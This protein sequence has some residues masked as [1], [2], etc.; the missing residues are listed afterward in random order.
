[1][2]SVEKESIEKIF[3]HVD[4]Q[5]DDVILYLGGRIDDDNLY[6]RKYRK[7]LRGQIER[8]NPSK[9]ICHNHWYAKKY[10]ENEILS[11]NTKID[12][13]L[14][15]HCYFSSGEIQTI[16]PEHYDDHL[17]WI[18][19]LIDK[20]PNIIY[21]LCID[22]GIPYGRSRYGTQDIGPSSV[23]VDD[24]WFG[25]DY[26]LNNIKYFDYDRRTSAK[27]LTGKDLGYGGEQI[28]ATGGFAM[29]RNILNAGFKN[30]NI[31]GFSAFGS[32]EDQ[33]HFTPY[34]GQYRQYA[35]VKYFN[36]ATSENQEAE[37]DILKYLVENERIYNLEDYETLKECLALSDLYSR[38]I[39]KHSRQ[40]QN[41]EPRA[42]LSVEQSEIKRIA[43]S[44]RGKGSIEIEKDVRIFNE[45]RREFRGEHNKPRLIK[46]DKLHPGIWKIVY[47]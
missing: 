22:D 33:S 36:I 8:L 45:V 7:Y 12:M 18:K 44:V 16:N 24:S 41:T 47:P 20:N 10:Y 25:E 19:I 29:I 5:E 39:Q 43:S 2:I 13:V 6:P 21:A 26:D 46:G 34:G 30:L 28:N 15:F 23:H 1:M 38:F 14:S 9:I 27:D 42:K 17:N 11:K 37:A 31:L 3:K 4:L 32:D 35:G 40:K